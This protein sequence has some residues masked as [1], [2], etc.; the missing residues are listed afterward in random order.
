[1]GQLHAFDRSRM[2]AAGGDPLTIGVR[3]AQSEN[4]SRRWIVRTHAD[5]TN[6]A[7][8][9]NDQPVALAGVMGKKPKSMTALKA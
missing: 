7:N 1:V 6:F 2:L 8:Y 4:R 9:R 5:S 3:F